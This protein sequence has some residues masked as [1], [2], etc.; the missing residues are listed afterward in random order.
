MKTNS[1]I[2]LPNK[3]GPVVLDVI[4]D[5]YILEFPSHAPLYTMKGYTLSVAK[6]VLSGTINALIQTFE[7][8]VALL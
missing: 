7:R 4:V 8:N 3:S 5:P 2:K 1:V 6:Q